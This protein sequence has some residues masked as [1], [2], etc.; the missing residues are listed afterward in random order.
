MIRNALYVQSGGPTTVINASAYGV[1]CESRQHPDRIGRLY[2]ARYGT[3]GV[4][5]DELVDTASL[6]QDDLARLPGTPSMAFGSCRYRMRDAEENGADYAKYLEVLR[7]HDI[8]YLFLNGGNGTLASAAKLH[9]Y[10]AAEGYDCK[11]MVIPKTV[12]NDIECIDHSP[13]FPSAARY[14]LISLSE[15]AHDIRSYDT[16][17][18]TVVEVMGRNTGWLAAATLATGIEGNGPDLIYVPEAPF[19][20]ERFLEDVRRIWLQKQKCLVVVAEGLKDETGRYVFEQQPLH[21]GDPSLNMGGASLYLADFLR[22]H[23]ECKVRSVDL[24]LMQRCAA[25]AASALDVEE[26]IQLG[27]RAVGEALGGATAR[28]VSL[29][30]VDCPGGPRFEDTLVDLEDAAVGGHLLP[31]HYITPD[32]CYIQDSFLFYILPLVGDLPR[33]AKTF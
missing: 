6:T 8:G 1:I 20:R 18:I 19:S 22:R 12:D 26:A 33:Y 9:R 17:L 7:K 30:R 24:G 27:R 16:G 21:E 11:V 2:A 5:G 28:M 29:K 25:H 15:L 31:A 32:G 3:V 10:L 4:L 23:F 14:V 13:G